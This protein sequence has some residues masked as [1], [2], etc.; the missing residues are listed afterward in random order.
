MKKSTLQIQPE[1]KNVQRA[2]VAP[3]SGFSM[4][5]DGHFKTQFDAENG[6]KKAATELLARYPMLKVEIYNSSTKKRTTVT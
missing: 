3:T 1:P 6:A 5:V 2:D 4:M